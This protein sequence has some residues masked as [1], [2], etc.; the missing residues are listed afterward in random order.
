[1]TFKVE[2]ITYRG[3][4]RTLEAEKINVPSKDGRRALLPNHMATIIPLELGVINITTDGKEKYYAVNGGMMSF[5]N[6]VATVLTDSIIDV[7][8][9]D[10]ERIE[11]KVKRTESY[12]NETLDE[13]DIIMLKMSLSKSLN[14]LEAKSKYG[15]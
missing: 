13:R 3:V 6:N 14:K 2:L 11:N 7:D 8:E 4:Y 9:I 15:K 12:L 10:Q 5:E 1:M